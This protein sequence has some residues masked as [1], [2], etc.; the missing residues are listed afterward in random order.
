MRD[1]ELALANQRLRLLGASC[2]RKLL[3][4]MK[5]LDRVPEETLR[6]LGSI[7]PAKLVSAPFGWKQK[8]KTLDRYGAYIQRYLCYYVR[9]WPLGRR[10]AEKQHKVRFS[11][12]NWTALGVVAKQLDHVAKA[13]T[14]GLM[15]ED[16]DPDGFDVEAGEELDALT[17]P[18]S[19]S[20]SAL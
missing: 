20:S 7:D 3:D 6:W 2:H 16:G 9:V 1:R 14:I 11:L 4:C 13:V 17:R 10:E 8:A 19:A 15:A 18:S 12:L 5:R